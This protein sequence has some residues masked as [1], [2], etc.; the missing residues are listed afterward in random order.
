MFFPR[1][2]THLVVIVL[3]ITK[4][5]LISFPSLSPSCY[6]PP[7]PLSFTS[8]QSCVS[9]GAVSICTGVPDQAQDVMDYIQ[10]RCFISIQNCLGHIRLTPRKTAT[11]EPVTLGNAKR[12]KVL[13]MHH[14]AWSSVVQ[15]KRWI[16]INCTA[17]LTVE[18]RGYD[19]VANQ[20]NWLL[21]ISWGYKCSLTD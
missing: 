15:I 21:Q 11:A 19:S 4:F 20:W 1:R 6:R 7:V 8:G 10:H 13:P 14:T 16:G 5:M 17:M 12:W 2:L 3:M 9:P 18:L